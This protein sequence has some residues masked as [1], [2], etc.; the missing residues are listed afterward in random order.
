MAAEPWEAGRGGLQVRARGVRQADSPGLCSPSLAHVHL[1][2][3][4]IK[5]NHDVERSGRDL[6]FE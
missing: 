2:V 5:A 1:T 4:E 3:F 6:D